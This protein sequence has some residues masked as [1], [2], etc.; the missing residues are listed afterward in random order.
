MNLIQLAPYAIIITDTFGVILEF[1]P[2][3]ESMF[4][5]SR[6]EVLG[7]NIA[8]T[9]IPPQYRAAHNNGIENYNKRRQFSLMIKSV[10]LWGMRKNGENFPIEMT[11][12]S[13]QFEGKDCLTSFVHDV[14]SSKESLE[15]LFKTYQKLD[16]ENKIWRAIDEA[17]RDTYYFKDESTLHTR[18]LQTSCE[19]I[20]WNLAQIFLKKQIQ[21]EFKLV[22]TQAWSPELFKFNNFVQLSKQIQFRQTEGLPGVAWDKKTPIW[23]EDVHQTK[24]FPRIRAAILDR[25]TSALSIPIFVNSELYGVIEFYS[26]EKQCENP[27]ILRGASILGSYFGKVLERNLQQHKESELL[28]QLNHASKL[29]IMGELAGGIA[30]EIKNPM[31]II[32]GYATILKKEIVKEPLDKETFKI[33]ID[34][35][36]NTT[37]RV[38]KIVNGLKKL[39]RD[40]SDDPFTISSM[41]QIVDDAIALCEPKL[42]KQSVFL[43]IVPYDEGLLVEAHSIQISQVIINLINNSVDAI[44]NATDRWIEIEIFKV[45]EFVEVRVTDSGPGIS[46]EIADKILQPFFTTKAPGQGTGLGLSLAKGIVELHNGKF[47]LD[48]QCPNTRFYFQIPIKQELQK[49]A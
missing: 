24:N 28:E 20:G 41:K 6:A 3:A 46:N 27:A 11:L 45:D 30:H 44:E 2:A 49:V 34:K 18:I 36:L 37:D 25:I 17:S 32:I 39:S 16:F 23:I 31:T 5:Y 35:I 33:T 42:K 15:T 10:E 43:K 4:E 21:N 14:S 8:D 13:S 1:N 29:S 48:R 26:V 22:F 40:D 38:V 19:A 12:A 7:K 47:D 9:I